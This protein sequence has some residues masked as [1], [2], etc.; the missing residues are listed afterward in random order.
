MNTKNVTLRVNSELYDAYMSYCKRNGLLASQQFEI[1]ME[2]KVGPDYKNKIQIKKIQPIDGSKE[3]VGSLTGE[4]FMIHENK[5]IAD[6]LLKNN[7]IEIIKKAV[8]TEN[9]LGY[10][11][12]KSVQKRAN[13]IIK[14]ISNLD[15]FL[16]NKIANDLSGDGKLVVLYSIYL[17]DRLF[18]EFMDEVMKEKFLIRDFSF[19]KKIIQ[20]FISD[21]SDSDIKLQEFTKETK[22]KLANVIFNILEEA[23]LLIETEK[24]FKLKNQFVSSE[25]RNYLE[26]KG[27]IKFL[28]SIGVSL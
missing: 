5:I 1:L 15:Q 7:T 11:T 3:Y 10:K 20:K 26:N 24:D 2:E 4:P 28:K 17:S 8:V 6:L 18:H 16:L 12:V 23:G 14:R 22:A 25:L 21:K 9:L 27:E 13:A 19:D